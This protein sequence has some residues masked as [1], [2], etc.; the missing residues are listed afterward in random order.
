[1]PEGVDAD[2]Y[3]VIGKDV[4]RILHREPAKVWV[5]VIERPI[6]RAKSDKALSNPRICQAKAPQSI[7]G[8][9]HVGAD[10]LAQIVIDKYRYLLSAPFFRLSNLELYSFSSSVHGR[11]LPRAIHR[12]VLSN[13]SRD[14]R[15]K[16]RSSCLYLGS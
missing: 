1:M 11:R 2:Q 8:G 16:P 13:S 4:T 3:D 10:M 15:S 9:N 5:E 7:I 14:E 12:L 6:L